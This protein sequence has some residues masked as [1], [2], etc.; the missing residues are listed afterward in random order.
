M[1][2][3]HASRT[4]SEKNSWTACLA[5]KMIRSGFRPSGRQAWTQSAS[6]RKRF[7]EPPQPPYAVRSQAPRSA[8]KVNLKIFSIFF[9][10][11]IY[12]LSLSKI[13]KYCTVSKES[14]IFLEYYGGHCKG[15]QKLS[16][17][18]LTNLNPK[19]LT[20]WRSQNSLKRVSDSS[21][22]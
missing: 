12:R 7:S 19:W 5:G 11:V 2:V 4:L 6:D 18:F 17:G 14:K 8:L 15:D 1:L 13:Y 22:N 16:D 10:G 20:N 3:P 9:Q 21:R